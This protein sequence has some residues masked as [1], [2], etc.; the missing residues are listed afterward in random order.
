MLCCN[1]FQNHW[2]WPTAHPLNPMAL[3]IDLPPS[4]L[5]AGI[6]LCVDADQKLALDSNDV[7]Q[8]NGGPKI[9]GKWCMDAVTLAAPGL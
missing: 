7:N 4:R 5:N 9:S 8:T 1:C 2:I 3:T 6:I